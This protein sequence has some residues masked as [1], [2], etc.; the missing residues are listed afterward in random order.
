MSELAERLAE[1]E[2]KSISVGKCSM[3]KIIGSLDDPSKTILERL[4]QN[5]MVSTRSIAIELQAAG[6]RIDRQTVT[7]HRTGRC[8]CRKDEPND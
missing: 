5:D 2:A 8:V 7:A 3:A 4:L 6:Y 1:L